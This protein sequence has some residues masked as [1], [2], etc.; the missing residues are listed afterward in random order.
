MAKKKQITVA[1]N[2]AVFN[3]DVNKFE[4]FNAPVNELRTGI[5]APV[6]KISHNSVTAI[7]FVENKRRRNILSSWGEVNVIGNILTQTHRDLLDC[8]LSVADQPLALKDG[9]VAYYFKLSDVS[10]EY[11][12]DK[13]MKNFNWIKEKLQEVQTTAIEFKAKDSK[14]FVSFSIL[15]TVAF[16]ETHDSY[17]IVFSLN[18]RKYV[19]EQ[20]TVDYKDELPKLL[21]IKS[22]LLKAII[23]FFWTHKHINISIE[24]VLK[25]IGFPIESDRAVRTAKKEIKDNA[26]ILEKEFGI[27]YNKKEN[28]LYTQINENINFIPPSSNPLTSLE[29]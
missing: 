2:Q 9:R 22:A 17:G 6:D 25:S 20:L 23:R 19:E 24:Q 28:F 12:P 4:N 7:K 8:V 18:Y 15:E 1:E 5:Y 21:K 10:K 11:A 16:S 13:D 26:E 27:F 3:F 29:N 14:S